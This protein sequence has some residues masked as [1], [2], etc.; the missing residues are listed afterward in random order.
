[1]KELKPMKEG[2][3]REVYDT[4]DSIVMVAT[5]RISAF[6]R[7]LKNEITKKG[8]ILTK[9]SKFMTISY[10]I[11]QKFPSIAV[12]HSMSHH[13]L[14]QHLYQNNHVLYGHVCLLYFAKVFLESYH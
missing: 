7:I 14:F 3:V 12:F 11:E 6:D 9:M 8:A 2:K 4:G 1:M 13:I 10:I 5:D